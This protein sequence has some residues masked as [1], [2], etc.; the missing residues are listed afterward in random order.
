MEELAFPKVFPQIETERL[1]L[2][3][4]TNQDKQAVFNNFSDPEVAKWFFDQPLTEMAQVV[5]IITAFGNEFK[6]GEGLTWAVE[7]KE[8]AKCIGTCGYGDINLGQRGEI[9]FDLARDRWGK[10]L[11]SEA[12]APVIAYGFYILRL[13]K[14]EAHSY[15]NNTRAINLLEKMGFQL[16]RI[17]EENHFYSISQNNFTPRRNN[18][19]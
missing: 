16:E 12:L 10:S 19:R 18:R 1:F 14:I 3:E 5:E 4:I 2:R 13:A 9:G 6:R 17:S 15:S 11:M 7:L 8:D